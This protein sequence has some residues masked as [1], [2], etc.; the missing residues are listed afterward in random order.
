MKYGLIGEKLSHSYS[1]ELHGFLGNEAY[2]L[3][4][5][6][7][8]AVGD[9]LRRADFLGINVTIP[10]KET[11][12]P[13]CTLD[14]SAKKIGSV[15]TIVN[16]GGTLHGYNTDYF[17]FS[18]MAR[19]E[20]ISFAG[21]RVVIL[22]SGGTSK[23]A[24]CVAR[25]QGAAAVAIV[26]RSGENN[27]ENLERHAQAD[28]LVN[29]TPVG[30]FPNTEKS[31]VAL[32]GF[33][34]LRAVMDVI[35]NP[36]RTKL[37]LD[38]RA[39][40]IPAANGLSMLAAQAFCAH[41]LFFAGEYGD[42]DGDAVI[43]EILRKTRQLHSNIVLIGMPGCGKTTI[44]AALAE[45]LGLP[46][47]DT[48]AVIETRTGRTG[49]DILREEGEPYFRALER[50][51]V[52]EVCAKTGQVIATGGGSVLLRENRDALAQNGVVLFLERPLGQLAT[53]G[54]PLS[55][56]L[57]VLYGRRL[58]LYEGLCGYKIQIG[59][60]LHANLRKIREALS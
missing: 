26:S 44:G 9:F 29:T 42:A 4:E 53:A 2:E 58:P 45:Q 17:G 47:V 20:G 35:Y 56:D 40:G 41:R 46:F 3:L 1:K 16:R 25:D 11:V 57:K 39:R 18:C 7:P 59:A 28:V 34:R 36:L 38:A 60:D 51:V 30:M 33:P 55:V 32:S 43:E 5:L 54:R 27:Y 15:N 6:P 14:E 10:Y 8:H 19:R 12:M 48:D 52:A 13:F 50:D 37:L 24:T 23:T 49:S 22:G 31:P 21:R